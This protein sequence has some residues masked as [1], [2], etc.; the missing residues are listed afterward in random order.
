MKVIHY[1]AR[2]GELK[3]AAD[4]VEDLW[5]LS[6]VIAPGEEVEGSSF[7]TYKVGKVEEKKAVK[8]RIKVVSVEFAEA[9]NRLRILGTIIWGEPEEFVQMGRHHTI[10]VAPGDKIKI[11]KK[12]MQHEVKRIKEAEKDTKKPKLNIVVLDE[13]HALFA[14]LKPYGIE[15]GLE[16]QNGARKR[17]EDFDKKEQDYFKKITEQLERM[18]GKIVVAGPGFSRDNLRKYIQQKNPDLIKQIIFDSCSYAEP[19]GVNELMKRGVLEKAVGLARFE[20]EEKEVEAFFVQIYK[21][22]GKAVYGAA[23]VK[24]ALQANAVEKL[25]VLDT[26]L[27]TSEEVQRL[28]EAG[29]KSGTEIFV[30]SAEGDPGLKLKNFGGVG[31]LLR[32][33]LV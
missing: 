24:K 17:S 27:R 6:K 14:T 13:E 16:L 32:W 5:H 26:L 28:I 20:K 15:Y 22:T 33:K 18:Q 11:K 4:T 23:E 3:V 12:W 9:S 29:E 10:E 8:I 7:R 25:L 1:N 19:S 31:A 2:E 30:V 21:E